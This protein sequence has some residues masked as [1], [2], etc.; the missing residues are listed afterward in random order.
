MLEL[1]YFLYI[2][3]VLQVLQSIQHLKGD[4]LKGCL[5]SN[6]TMIRAIEAEISTP[7]TPWTEKQHRL[8]CNGHVINLAVH[9]FLFKKKKGVKEKMETIITA[10]ECGVEITAEHQ[11]TWRELG[12]MGKLHNMAVYIRG[13]YL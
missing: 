4:I 11:K 7:E 10:E 5:A 9:A 13:M 12:P 2:L 6:D 8:H 1:T 3:I